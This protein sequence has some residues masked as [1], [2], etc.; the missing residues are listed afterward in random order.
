MLIA[1]NPSALQ[2]HATLDQIHAPVALIAIRG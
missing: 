2:A 1:E